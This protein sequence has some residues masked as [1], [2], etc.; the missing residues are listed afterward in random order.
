[1][2]SLIIESYKVPRQTKIMI[3]KKKLWLWLSW[4]KSDW[5]YFEIAIYKKE[6]LPKLY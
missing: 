4:K 2:C 3:M 6:S 1:M 5:S